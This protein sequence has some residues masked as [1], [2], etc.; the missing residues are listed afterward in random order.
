[1]TLLR[2]RLLFTGCVVAGAA[3]LSWVLLADS[4]PL[5]NYFLWHTSLPNTWAMLN[6]PSA[7]LGVVV[8]GNVHQPHPVGI[9]AGM[10]VEW[11]VAA[12]VLSLLLIRNR[13]RG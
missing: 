13:R 11:G 9:V 5:R 10:G 4:S 12:F 6:F 2:R 8:S 3:I 1:L 7:L